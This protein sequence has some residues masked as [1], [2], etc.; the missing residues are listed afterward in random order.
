MHKLLLLN[1]I[2]T[3][4]NTICSK[5]RPLYLPNRA[6]GVSWPLWPTARSASA[7]LNS[8]Y[9]SSEPLE[10]GSGLPWATIWPTTLIRSSSR[11]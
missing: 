11:E 3:L 6:R 2:I 7:H 4:K 1:I 5:N 8:Y 10:I 9:V